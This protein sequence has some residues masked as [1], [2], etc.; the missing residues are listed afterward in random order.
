MIKK[1]PWDKREGAFLK[2]VELLKNEGYI[3]DIGANIG[4]MTYHF[5]KKLPGSTIH[6]FEPIPV[7]FS[8]LNKIKTR[9]SLSNVVLYQMALGDKNEHVKMI[10]PKINWVRFHG[11][12]HIVN[13]EKENGETFT[14]DMYKLD[15]ISDF[16]N[17]DIQAIKIDV[18]NFEYQVLLGAEKLI[19]KNRPLIYCELWESENKKNCFDFLNKLNYSVFT[20]ESKALIPFSEKSITQNFFF[21][22]VEHCEKLNLF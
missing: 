17:F 21:I 2:F 20:Y 3:I 13:D 10:L 22:P 5:A 7:N 4:V 19:Q 14:V 6:S 8:I 11:L 16:S 18:E 1:L 12:S 15:D 9:F